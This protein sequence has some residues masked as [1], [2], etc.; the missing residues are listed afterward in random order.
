[1]TFK[2]G[3]V[4]KHKRKGGLIGKVVSVNTISYSVKLNDLFTERWL[5]HMVKAARIPD[6]PIARKIHP[7]AEAKDGWLWLRD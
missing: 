6:N 2:P 7:N 3:D 1:M 4:V 5:K